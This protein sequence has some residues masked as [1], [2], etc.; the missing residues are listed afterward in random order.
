MNRKGQVQYYGTNHLLDNISYCLRALLR[1][2]LHESVEEKKRVLSRCTCLEGN[3]PGIV[4]Q[5]FSAP[6]VFPS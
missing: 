1:K 5:A 6:H 2:F 3:S 4:G